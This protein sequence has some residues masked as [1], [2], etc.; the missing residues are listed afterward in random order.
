M[1]ITYDP[2]YNVAYLRF[3]KKAA[4]VR[5]LQI[6]DSV[7]VDIGSNGILHGIELLNVRKQLGKIQTKKGFVVVN[8]AA[9]KK[10]KMSVKK[11]DSIKS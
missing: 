2:K 8:I 5:T 11:T 1:K 6:T 4:R 10:R 9:G 3:K 7:N